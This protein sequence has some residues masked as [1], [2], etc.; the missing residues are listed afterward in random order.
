MTGNAD[1][2]GKTNELSESS[3]NPVAGGHDNSVVNVSL[4]SSSSEARK[5][6]SSVSVQR[7]LSKKNPILPVKATYPKS[8]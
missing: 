2:H 6:P 4:P 1:D 5:S 8:I 7:N 3:S